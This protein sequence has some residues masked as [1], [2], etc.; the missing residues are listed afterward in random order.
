M[1][2]NLDELWL[3]SEKFELGIKLSKIDFDYVYNHTQ[4]KIYYLKGVKELDIHFK[5]NSNVKTGYVSGLESTKNA[6][7]LYLIKYK[8][9]TQTDFAKIIIERSKILHFEAEEKSNLEFIKKEPNKHFAK[10]FVR[11]GIGAGILLSAIT[12]NIV[13]V[14]TESNKGLIYKLF[15]NNL[16]GEKEEIILYTSEEFKNE[17]TLFLNTY[18]KNILPE[19]ANKPKDS[20]DTSCF[21]ATASYKDLYSKEVVFFRYYRDEYLLKKYFGKL[22]VK[23]Y[24]SVSPY[25]YNILF[26]NKKLSNKTKQI[27]DIIYKYLVKK[28]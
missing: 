4:S 2:L 23:V 24:Y 10:N 13:F 22:L 6:I 25:F 15:Y 26:K 16:Y 19:E 14:N 8:G 5:E 9:D 11:R 12:D 1:K 28:Y 20:S 7:I 3:N 18:Y 27:L 21:I 17:C